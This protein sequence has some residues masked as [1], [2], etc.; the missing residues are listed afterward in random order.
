[1]VFTMSSFRASSCASFPPNWLRCVGETRYT[2]QVNLRLHGH[3]PGWFVAHR[4]EGERTEETEERREKREEEKVGYVNKLVTL[5]INFSQV[6]ENLRQKHE[7]V[8]TMICVSLRRARL[9]V[10]CLIRGK[11]VLS[12]VIPERPRLGALKLD[13]K[14]TDSCFPR[15][16]RDAARSTSA[17]PP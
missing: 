6:Q 4:G 10:T 9:G 2:K 11:L 3:T 15:G 17:S 7:L 1:M 12:A 14:K 13:A 8:R 5:E 16:Q